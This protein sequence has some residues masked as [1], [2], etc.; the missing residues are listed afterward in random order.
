MKFDADIHVPQIMKH[1]D[2]P[3]HLVALSSQ[4]SSQKRS[5]LWIMNNIPAKLI[6]FIS[7]VLI[8]KNVRILITR[9]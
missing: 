7:L 9:R 4:T 6:V 5:K 1:I 2:F 3:F 8:S